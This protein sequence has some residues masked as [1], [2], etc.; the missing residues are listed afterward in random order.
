MNII[1]H[2]NGLKDK[3]HTIISVDAEKASEDDFLSW[4]SYS[5]MWALGIQHN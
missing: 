3:N 4:F 2:I 1:N 5:V